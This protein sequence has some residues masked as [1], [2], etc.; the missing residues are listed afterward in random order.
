METKNWTK[1]QAI[2][3]IQLTMER[4]VVFNRYWDEYTCIEQVVDFRC[5]DCDFKMEVKKD[6]L[7]GDNMAILWLMTDGEKDCIVWEDTVYFGNMEWKAEDSYEAIYDL[8]HRPTKKEYAAAEKWVVANLK[9]LVEAGITYD[10]ETDRFGV[11]CWI[12]DDGNWPSYEKDRIWRKFVWCFGSEYYN[13]N[14]CFNEVVDCYLPDPPEYY[15]G[16][17]HYTS[18]CFT[19]DEG[20][21]VC[22]EDIE[23]ECP[24]LLEWLSIDRET[25]KN[26]C[27]ERQE[28]KEVVKW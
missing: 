4:S 10:P 5:F 18:D 22:V 8:T 2:K 11:E 6:E 25:L 26:K 23:S 17:E 16:W 1:K 14:M 28:I 21:E 12:E 24:Q 19:G 15:D 7:S 20:T 13:F 27:I 3:L 9:R